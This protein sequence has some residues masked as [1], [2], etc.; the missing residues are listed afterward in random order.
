MI[1]HSLVTLDDKVITLYKF[2]KCTLSV[3]YDERK[4]RKEFVEPREVFLGNDDYSILEEK[5][6][7]KIQIMKDK[8]M[9]RVLAILLVMKARRTAILPQEILY[10][11]CLTN[12]PENMRN[13]FRN[14]QHKLILKWHGEN[15]YLLV[16]HSQLGRLSENKVDTQRASRSP[17]LQIFI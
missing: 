17:N 15:N 11:E 3:I 4:G 1:L 6:N 10:G 7:C 12:E 13:L 2:K 9:L 14:K 16:K 5:L 8:P